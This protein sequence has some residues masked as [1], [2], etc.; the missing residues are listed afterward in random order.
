MAM[1]RIDEEQLLRRITTDPAIF[2]G[3]PIIR[4]RRLA[5]EHVLAMLA[6][7]D[8]PE[9][10]LQ[11]YPW[12]EMDDIRACLVYARR[13]VGRERVEPLTVESSSEGTP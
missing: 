12:L 11:G 3:K 5:V 6:L 9:T 8:T 4:G 1:T 13:L 7:G 10:I 2:G